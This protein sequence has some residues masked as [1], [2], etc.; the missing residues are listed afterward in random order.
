MT[1]DLIASI[2]ATFELALAA[3]GKSWDH[4][5]LMVK[6]S[7]GTSQAASA[8]GL[9]KSNGE[10]GGIFLDSEIWESL[11]ELRALLQ[12]QSG[13]NVMR[14]RI[15]LRSPGASPELVY[16]HDSA[17]GSAD[18][19]WPDE[20]GYQGRAY[21][22]PEVVR[23]GNSWSYQA[24]GAGGVA[25]VAVSLGRVRA[26]LAANALELGEMLN[27][28]ATAE[29]IAAVEELLGVRFP[30]SLR[31]AYLIHD[32]QA[33]SFG[34]SLVFDLVGW[35]SLDTVVETMDSLSQA[36]GPRDDVRLIPVMH[37][38][39]PGSPMYVESVDGELDESELIRWVVRDNEEW[40][41]ADSFAA[42]L[43]QFADE[44]ESNK[45]VFH[46]GQLHV[47]ADL[48]ELDEDD[49]D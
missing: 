30:S 8:S 21:V 45:F 41:Q 7:D 23:R 2:A 43:E 1:S 35:H 34:A 4:A 49:L 14:Y 39:G 11:S 38:A 3:Q 12:E 37:H 33:D 46:A 15:A 19:V 40:V 20:P 44:L 6:F 18:W 9:Y 31:D 13:E 17:L 36:S 26:W 42:F 25:S 22:E 47:I 10:L 24:S 16:F 27:P 32:G 28:P 48:E 5:R 29:Q